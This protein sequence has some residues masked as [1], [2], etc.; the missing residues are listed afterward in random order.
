MVVEL[1]LKGLPKRYYFGGS[2]LATKA[3]CCFRRA[4]REQHRLT[5]R[6][7]V[8]LW[9]LLGCFLRVPTGSKYPIS[10]YLGLGLIVQ[11]LGKYVIIGYLDP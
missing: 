8:E 2:R 7:A 9:G 5:K 10:R 3:S 1:G 11:G 4:V 6:S